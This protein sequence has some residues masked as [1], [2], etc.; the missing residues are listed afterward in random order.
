MCIMSWIG[1]AT[2]ALLSIIGLIKSIDYI[3]WR[4]PDLF[5]LTGIGRLFK[6]K[7]LS[8]ML[9]I[10]EISATRFNIVG[11]TFHGGNQYRN[12][13]LWLVWTSRKEGR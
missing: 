7:R 10:E 9:N 5:H 12:V 4:I 6:S 1:I 2:V 8:E 11:P 3:C 13:G